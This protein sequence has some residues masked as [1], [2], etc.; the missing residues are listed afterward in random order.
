MSAMINV[1]LSERLLTLRAGEPPR[2]VQL[3]L[4]N[5]SNK[6]EDYVIRVRLA[7][8]KLPVLDW[9]SLT[10]HEVFGLYPAGVPGQP[11]GTAIREAVDYYGHIYAGAHVCAEADIYEVLD[12]LRRAVELFRDRGRARLV[13]H[14][15]RQSEARLPQRLQGQIS[16][17][18]RG[19]AVHHPS[20]AVDNARHRNADS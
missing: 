4:Q 1:V 6:I 14:D 16:P 11:M 7:G 13:L 18:Q 19:H 17:S 20:L 15:H 3:T 2:T 9:I 10:P 8:P 5:R 12:A